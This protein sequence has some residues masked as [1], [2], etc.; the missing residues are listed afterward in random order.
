MRKHL[1]EEL[2]WPEMITFEEMNLSV[3]KAY[4]D[5]V[6]T[7]GIIHQAIID[8]LKIGFINDKYEKFIE[9]FTLPKK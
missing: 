8:L 7:Y 1:L 3:P 4:H 9:Q 2:R 6:V 5:Q